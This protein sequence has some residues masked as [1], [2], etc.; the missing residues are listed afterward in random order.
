MGFDLVY[1]GFW[2]LYMMHE[3]CDEAPKLRQKTWVARFILQVNQDGAGEGEAE[4]EGDEEETK[5]QKDDGEVL[6]EADAA[7]KIPDVA[8]IVRVR[9]PKKQP[10]PELDP[11]TG[12]ALDP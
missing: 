11:E 7:P 2:D 1:E 6:S 3:K 10:D 12:E 8:A 4:G 9:I 5:V